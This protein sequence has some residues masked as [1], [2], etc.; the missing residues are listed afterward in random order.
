MTPTKSAILGLVAAAVGIKRPNTARNGEER[1]LWEGQ[2]QKLAEGYGVATRVNVLGIPLIDYHTA[3]VPSSGTGRNRKTF[4]TR[5]DELT[6]GHRSELNTILSR[7]EYRQ[8]SFCAVALWSKEGA[9]YTLSKLQHHLICP[10]FLLYLGRKACPL[11]LPLNPQIIQSETIE[12]ALN[13][14]P[15]PPEPKGIFDRFEGGTPT[16]CWDDGAETQ[17]EEQHTFFRRDGILSRAR[18]QFEVRRE[19]QGYLPKGEGL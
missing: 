13:V 4:P 2:H 12:K 18:W 1:E 9:P 8:D 19:H 7:R 3:Q 16:Y 17:L 15:F 14:I 10:E 5:R 11:S 6:L